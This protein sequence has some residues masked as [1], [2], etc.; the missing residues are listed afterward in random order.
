MNRN[1]LLHKCQG[2]STCRFLVNKEFQHDN[3]LGRYWPY[4]FPRACWSER[5]HSRTAILYVLLWL[6]D[7]LPAAEEVR[8]VLWLPLDRPDPSAPSPQN[9]YF[10]DGEGQV[11]VLLLLGFA[12]SAIYYE[13]KTK[14]NKSLFFFL[15]TLECNKNVCFPPTPQLNWLHLVAWKKIA[16]MSDWV[17]QPP[18][19]VIF[20][21]GLEHSSKQFI[22]GSPS[23]PSHLFA[24]KLCSVP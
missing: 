19:V 16:K 18:W 8:G 11:E 1:H 4:L 2:L 5:E 15:W 3:I 22:L 24:Y 17:T 10:C 21:S 6:G 20:I 12:W 9:S 7:F 23:L 13:Q 14:Q